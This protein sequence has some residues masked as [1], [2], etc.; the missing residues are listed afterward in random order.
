MQHQV[1]FWLLT[2]QVHRGFV[3]LDHGRVWS[4]KLS[5]ET[6][7]LQPS[8]FMPPLRDHLSCI[9]SLLCPHLSFSKSQGAACRRAYP[10]SWKCLLHL[11]PIRLTLS[12]ST[13]ASRGKCQ[14]TGMSSPFAAAWKQSCNVHVSIGRS[15]VQKKIFLLRR[16]LKY[17]F[18]E[19]DQSINANRIQIS[20]ILRY[21]LFQMSKCATDFLPE[22]E[23]DF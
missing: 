9:W 8:L 11:Y 3:V 23:R 16:K 13:F 12:S 2:L 18:K 22:S 1:C 21:V 15:E 17:S 19:I 10:H 20:V 4:D 7:S 14:R 5:L 6:S